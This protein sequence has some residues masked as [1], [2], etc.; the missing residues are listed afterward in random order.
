[1]SK[2]RL[3]EGDA[4]QAVEKGR[5]ATMSDNE[6]EQELIKAGVDLALPLR[7]SSSAETIDCIESY[8]SETADSEAVRNALLDVAHPEKQ[9]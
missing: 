1:M 7:R 5:G 2:Y 3:Q 4:L 6:L 8:S 9:I